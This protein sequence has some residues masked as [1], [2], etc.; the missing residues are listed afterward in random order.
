M[1]INFSTKGIGYS[2]GNKGFRYTHSSNGKNY[3]TYS[4][5]RTGISY[6]QSRNNHMKF[7][8]KKSS[9]TNAKPKAI[10]LS[11]F[12]IVAFGLFLSNCIPSNEAPNITNDP[13]E[14]ERSVIKLLTLNQHPRIFDTYE[15]AQK[16]YNDIEEKCIKLIDPVELNRIKRNYKSSTD[17]KNMLYLVTD[18]QHINR[19]EF[20]IECTN[21]MNLSVQDVTKII[22]DYLPNKF[23]Y[24]YIKDASYIYFRETTTVY[25]YSARLNNDGVEYR[26]SIAQQYSFYFYFRIFCH[27][28]GKYWKVETGATAYGDKDKGWIEKYA[29]IWDIELQSLKGT[30]A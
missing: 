7:K 19:L 26:N 17:D 27:D 21:E 15:S 22:I 14:S 24:Y 28:N 25:T 9:T 6:R 30:E 5:P 3:S 2:I 11:F 20:S 4:I 29:Q 10:I 12:L 1:R 16:Y 8:S 23:F 18:S 13:V